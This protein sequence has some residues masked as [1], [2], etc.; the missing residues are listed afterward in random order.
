[1][2][3]EKANEVN[4]SEEIRKILHETPKKPVK[5]IVA[6]LGERGIKVQPGLVYFIKGKMKGKRKGKGRGRGTRERVARE[7]GPALSIWSWVLKNWPRRR[8]AWASSN[9]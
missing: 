3:K 2:A 4:K 7:G 5:E 6:T 1:M 8:G 9:S